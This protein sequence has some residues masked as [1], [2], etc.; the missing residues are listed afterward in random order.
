[1]EEKTSKKLYAAWYE[2]FTIG[3]PGIHLLG[4]YDSKEAA[5]KRATDYK[6]RWIKSDSKGSL[7]EV[8]VCEMTLNEDCPG[9]PEEAWIM[10]EEGEK[11]I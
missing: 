3:N 1:M 5:E 6:N 2:D 10:R 4:I 9:N 7:G 8:W 11:L